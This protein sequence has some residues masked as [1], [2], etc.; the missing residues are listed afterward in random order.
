MG[1]VIEQGRPYLE[2]QELCQ[3]RGRL[4]SLRLRA[5]TT[6]VRTAPFR[7]NI[8][9]LQGMVQRAEA[10]DEELKDATAILSWAQL[11]IQE[12]VCDICYEEQSTDTMP[13]CGR[14]TGGGR[15][16]SACL[17]RP[18]HAVSICPFCRQPLT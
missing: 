3:A 15:I 4:A 6:R 2:R 13:C 1:E 11:S 5:A 8:D 7:R 12:E 16:C 10:E 9:L 17:A 14:E 18:L